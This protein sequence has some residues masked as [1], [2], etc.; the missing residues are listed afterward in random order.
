MTLAR[1]SRSSDTAFSRRISIRRHATETPKVL[2]EEPVQMA[3]AASKLPR[4]LG[5]AEVDHLFG[6][7]ILEHPRP[8]IFGADISDALAIRILEL[9]IQNSRRQAQQLAAV[10]QV[11]LRRDLEEQ[12]VTVE[13]QSGGSRIKPRA[14]EPVHDGLQQRN[15][16]AGK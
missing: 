4:Q 10:V 5:H 14:S 2:L 3:P 11:H 9:L 7:E 12:F 16:C 13:R 15:L 1:V 8:V 6:G